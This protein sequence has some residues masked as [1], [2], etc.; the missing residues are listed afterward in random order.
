MAIYSMAVDIEAPNA[1]A[2]MR[3]LLAVHGV[4]GAELV[5]PQHDEPLEVC[6]ECGESIPDDEPDMFNAYHK[7]SCSLFAAPLA[8]PD[9]DEVARFEAEGGAPC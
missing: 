6:D 4:T 3:T 1:A 7:P 8:E 2:A 9:E 5:W